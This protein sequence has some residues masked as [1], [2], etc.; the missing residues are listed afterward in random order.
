[1]TASKF[2]LLVLPA[3]WLTL[4]SASPD[5]AQSK[6]V[7]DGAYTDAQ[8]ARGADVYGKNC[9]S[10]H[11]DGLDGDGFAP[12]LS[13]SEFLSNWNGTS[14]GDLFDRIR[15]S[16]PPS[17]PGSVSPQSKADIIA[18]LLK[19]NKYPAGKA[20]LAAELPALKDIKIELPK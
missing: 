11:G 14:V 2:G 8:A 4:V 7:V 12:A 17:S 10:C 1:M 15:L 9:S 20:E 6:S 19:S 13:G 5:A 18:H 16:M 3:V